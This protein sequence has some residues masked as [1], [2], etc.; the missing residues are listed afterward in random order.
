[1]SLSGAQ[2][3]E[4]E[5]ATSQLAARKERFEGLLRAG[6]LDRSGRGEE[7]QGLALGIHLAAAGKNMA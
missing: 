7:T 4:S 6:D 5:E 3:R 1:M 2:A